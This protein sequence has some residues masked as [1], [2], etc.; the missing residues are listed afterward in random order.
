LLADIFNNTQ[1]QVTASDPD[2]DADQ[3]ALRY[4]L[5]GQGA[6]SEFM[7]DEAT[8]KIYAQRTLDREA[9]AVW[10]F[11]VL[12]TD[13]GG[14]GLTGFTDVI[15]SVWDINDNAPVF[16]CAPDSCHGSVAENSPPGTSVMELTATDLDD[17]AVGQ[18]AVLAY[19][20]V[21]NTVL[22]GG[23]S[24]VDMFTINGATGTVSV[25]A[26]GLD[27]EKTE[28]Y[29]LV[30]EAR[31]GGGM[32]GT[33][34]ATISV[35]D[36]NDH[37]P[38]FLERSC[39]A[40]IPE[41]SEP[42]TAVL[43]L[44][45]EDADAGENGQ[46]TFSIVA[47]DPEQKFYM[48]SHRQ[49]QRGTLRLKKRLD[50][51]RPGEQKFN[52]TIKVEDLEYSSLL[53]CTLDVE[54]Y[55]DHAPVF[56]PHFLQLPALRE[57]IPVGSSVAMVA[58]SDSDSGSNREITYS[59]APESDPHSLFLVDQT[60]LVTV[61]R[62]LDREEASQH[63]LVI[64]ATDHGDPPLTGTATIQMSLLDVNDNGPEFEA[65]YAPVVWENVPGPQVVH[66]NASSTLLRAIDRDSAE[67]G[68]PFSFSVPPEYRYSNDFLLRE[69]GNDTAT[70][71]ALR[72]FDRERQKEFLLPVIMTDSGKPPQTVTK[73]QCSWHLRCL[74]LPRLASGTSAST[75]ALISVRTTLS[76]VLLL[77]IFL[78][79]RWRSYKGLK[80]GVYH[81][82]AHHDGWEDIRE[83]VLNYDE[84]GGGEEDQVRSFSWWS[85]APCAVLSALGPPATNLPLS[86]RSSTSSTKPRPRAAPRPPPPAPPP[87]PLAII[88]DADQHPETAPFDSL[89]V[90]S[91]EGGGSPAGSLSSFSSAGLEES[92]ATHDSLREWGPRFEKLRALYERAEGSDL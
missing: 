80:E 67:N 43:E 71:T 55:N 34:T 29:L 24:I 65:A 83:N 52:L 90:F 92:A 10:R 23:S 3:E 36:I 76:A 2:K 37:A 16:G 38:H 31:D 1:V 22:S 25:A 27:R 47:G 89:Q 78:Y 66:L 17:T 42:N 44:A 13:E 46:L 61:A 86:S 72:A 26:A 48:V 81:V 57:D 30:V 88:R 77:G 9:R 50:Y 5:H 19:R 87:C 15:I 79:T 59:I 58:A 82:S 70:V 18:N 35:M 60:G 56:I 49:E 62:Q 74:P 12:A 69:N 73:D 39:E 51:E 8:G 75:G 85:R 14:E 7:I 11:V 41:S 33:A 91:T 64:L 32:M 20:I 21:G 28:S 54:D 4:S 63:H 84:E 40:R 68:S 53:H 45:A 6:E